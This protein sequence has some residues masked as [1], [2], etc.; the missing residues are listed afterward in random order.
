VVEA[1]RHRISIKVIQDKGVYH[2]T[3]DPSSVPG[4]SDSNHY[5]DR[6]VVALS[7]QE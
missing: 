1:I 2:G 3:F 4:R 7:G 5:P 6:I